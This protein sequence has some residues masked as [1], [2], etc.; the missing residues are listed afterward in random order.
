M[1]CSGGVRAEEELSNVA[2]QDRQALEKV[3]RALTSPFTPRLPEDPLPPVEQKGP[4][5]AQ[6]LQK[7]QAEE[8]Q[9]AVER[10]VVPPPVVA[11]VQLPPEPPL[12]NLVLTGIVYNPKKPQAII[13]GKVVDLGQ[14]VI[15]GVVV[16]EIT[17]SKVE[18][19]FRGLK[20]TLSMDEPAKPK[21]R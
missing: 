5:E 4:S 19:S 15:E 10:K 7:K 16:T 17:K 12:P 20:H 18:V 21:V 14:M 3:I 9:K 8:K 1:L 11:A 6:L 13:N 2:P